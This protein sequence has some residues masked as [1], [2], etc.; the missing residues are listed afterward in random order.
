MR[1]LRITDVSVCPP[2]EIQRRLAGAFRYRESLG[3]D[4]NAM[5][6]VN[7]RG[8]GLDGLIIDRFDRHF[9]VYLLDARWHAHQKMICDTLQEY[10]DVVYLVLKDHSTRD[11]ARITVD[12]L[13]GK[14]DSRTMVEENGLCFYADLNDN[15]NQG[16][17]MDMRANRRRVA[18]FARG[19]MVL[20]CFA[21]TCSFGVYCRKYGA[22][23]VMNVDISSKFLDR[24]RENYRLNHL[25]GEPGEF[26]RENALRYLDR[27]AG[28]GSL[29]D[30]IIL[31]PPSFSRSDG[32]VFSVKRDMPELIR[33]AFRVLCPGGR[34]FIST[35]LSEVS[36]GRLEEWARVAAGETSRKMAGIQRLS[37]DADFRGSGSMKESS[38]SAVFFKVSG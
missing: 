22:S 33:K 15:L 18:A 6:L 23:R 11:A 36:H 12:V 16:L 26:I 10:F 9:A 4:T 21:Y 30:M 17:F 2:R 32:K 27:S 19:R 13:I 14:A 29:F 37:Q 28:R 34:L 8:D 20:N 25:S 24:G 7:S 1:S 35:N 31:D 38:L 5:R 3:L